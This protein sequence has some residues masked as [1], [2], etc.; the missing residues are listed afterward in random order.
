M[1][2]VANFVLFARALCKR[3]RVCVIRCSFLE[4]SGLTLSQ[5]VI[6]AD[7][8]NFAQFA[9]V[10]G[11]LCEIWLIR[12][13]FPGFSVDGQRSETSELNMDQFTAKCVEFA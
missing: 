1:A 10:V 11:E 12:S 4:F 8:A 5:L 13:N 2:N 3:C 9:G 6:G 7:S